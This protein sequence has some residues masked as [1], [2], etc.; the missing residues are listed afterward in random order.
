MNYAEAPEIRSEEMMLSAPHVARDSVSSICMW[1]LL[2]LLVLPGASQAQDAS[3]DAQINIIESI[4]AEVAPGSTGFISVEIANLGPET[5]N[6]F[7]D[8]PFGREG[9]IPI[10]LL[11][12]TE[13]IEN[14]PN[15]PSCLVGQAIT[16]PIPFVLYS[17]TP[18]PGTPPYAPDEVRTCR[19]KYEV[20]ELAFPGKIRVTG[21]VRPLADNWT[22]PD[23]SNNTVDFVW[24]VINP[25]SPSPAPAVGVPVGGI[26]LMLLLA[27]ICIVSVRRRFRST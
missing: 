20:S 16:N 22:D 18:F 17:L 1:C 2:C 7:V 15:L 14:P 21:E 27:A 3:V 24:N 8:I 19:F 26:T 10:L 13:G 12:E 11:T 9:E 5:G 4:P 23:P 6:I 25:G